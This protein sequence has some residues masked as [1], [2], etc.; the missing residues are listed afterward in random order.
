MTFTPE[1]LNR[2]K[3]LLAERKPRALVQRRLGSEFALRPA[4]IRAL[5]NR[6]IAP[7]ERRLWL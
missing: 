7:P 1:M 6:A 4:Q 3:S 5:I 2:A